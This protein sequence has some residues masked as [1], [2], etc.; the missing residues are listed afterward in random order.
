MQSGNS[1]SQ[2]YGTGK[3]ALYVKVWGE[4]HCMQGYSTVALAAWHYEISALRSC[5]SAALQ[6]EGHDAQGGVH[7]SSAGGR[8]LPLPQWQLR[9]GCA[10]RYWDRGAKQPI[11]APALPSIFCVPQP[12]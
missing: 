9:N 6:A 11:C 7:L 10:E 5:C 12:A 1:S 2:A 8:N 3:H 4:A